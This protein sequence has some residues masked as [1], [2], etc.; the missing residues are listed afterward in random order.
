MKSAMQVLRAKKSNSIV[1][2]SPD[3]TVYEAIELM[4]DKNV[5]A[6]LVMDGEK[7]VGMLSERDYARKIILAGRASKETMVKD[8]M[9]KELV[10]IKPT[11]S[12]EE[13]MAIMTEK[14]L[15][16]LP[17]LEDG[18]VVGLVSIGDAVKT[19]ISEQNFVIS[20]LQQ[21]IMQG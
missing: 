15:R 14:F 8:V 2:I 10:V 20:N 17:V 16:H 9:T 4:C 18:K 1:S 7:L 3:A 13:C 6:L 11:T 21:Y 5:G 19:I 12:V